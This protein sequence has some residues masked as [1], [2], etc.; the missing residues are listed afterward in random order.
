MLSIPIYRSARGFLDLL[1][2]SPNM[3][4]NFA[5]CHINLIISH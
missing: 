4:Q 1:Y 5:C 3:L 2:S